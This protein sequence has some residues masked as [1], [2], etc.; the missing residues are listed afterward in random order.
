MVEPQR[1]FSGGHWWQWDGQAWV[2]EPAP[3]GEVAPDVSQDQAP[4]LSSGDA[5]GASEYQAPPPPS[6][7][8]AAPVT[9]AT[10][11]SWL[12]KYWW[13]PAIVIGVLV[14]V[15]AVFLFRPKTSVLEAAVATCSAQ[16]ADGIDLADGGSTLIV[17]TKGEEDFSG[18]TIAQLVCVLA[19]LKVPAA[20]LN[21]IQRTSSN[22]GIQTAEWDDLKASW[23]YH[24]DDGMNIQ[25]TLQ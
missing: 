22:D 6:F 10:Q 2:L 20:D 11:S 21:A 9:S 15:G 18:S 24:P 7:A 3:P 12:S 16:N 25:F 17:D 4:P 23:K 5:A 1:Q 14:V 19:A 8:A 13:I